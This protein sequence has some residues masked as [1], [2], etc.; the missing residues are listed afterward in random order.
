MTGMRVLAKTKAVL[1]YISLACLNLFERDK[2]Q[3]DGFQSISQSGEGYCLPYVILM[4][5]ELCLNP[6]VY[7][8]TNGMNELNFNHANQMSGV[9]AKS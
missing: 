1:K 4:V 3:T 7:P 5:R 2:G 9:I 8:L 6:L